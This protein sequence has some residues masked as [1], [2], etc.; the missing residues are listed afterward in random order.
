MRRISLAA[1]LSLTSLWFG[2]I[3]SAQQS[4]T[5]AVPNLIRYGGTLKDA[6]GA[7]IAATTGVTFAIYKQ[8]DGGA[9]VW[10]ETQNVTPD[11][12]GQYSVLLGSTTATGLPSDLFSQEEQRWLGVQVQGQAEQPRV[13]LVSVPYA[14][15][16][17]EAE[18]LAG[19]S[20]SDF[21][22]AKDL[23]SSQA[24]T[25]AGSSRAGTS[26]ENKLQTGKA[27]SKVAAASAGPTNFS[28]STTD[29]I[30]GVAQTGSGAG[31]NA[32]AST[33][34]VVG[35]ATGPSGIALYGIATSSN[36]IGVRGISYNPSGTGV[37]GSN[38]AG[39]GATT[40]ISAYVG[41]PSGTAAV[42]NNAAGGKIISGQ[43]NGVEKFSVG[44]SGNVTAAGTLSGNRTNT[45]TTYQ[46][47]GSTV[48]DIGHP[49]DGN[50]FVGAGAGVNN[51][52]GGDTNTF[53]G[54]LAG[55]ANT[56]GFGNTF[57]GF[58]AGYS[59][60]YGFY[61]TFSGDVAGY[62]NTTACCNVFS[63][64]GAG[65]FNTTGHDN[66]LIGYE[67]GYPNTTGYYNT[68]EGSLTGGST[69]GSHNI[70][71]GYA[72][73][74]N[75]STGSNDIYIANEGPSSGNESN[76]IRIGG[77]TG[78]GFGPQT[79]AYIAGIYGGL[80]SGGVSVYVNSNG[81]LGTGS[82][83]LRF[84]EQVR[85]MGDSSNAL[86]KLRPVTFFYRPEYDDGSHTLQYGLIAEE[87]AE[88]YPEMVAYD[89]DGQPYT[90]K[91]QYLA[92]MLLNELQ[93]QHAVVE[94]QQDV[95][96]MQQR[97]VNAQQGQIESLQKQDAE[98]QQRLARLESRAGRQR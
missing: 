39:S 22:L 94:A 34:A 26:A 72:A 38:S 8:Q 41:S 90:V 23:N 59:N 42:F 95:I 56:S 24:A 25:E 31:V 15:K 80:S 73:G 89:K 35:T 74:Y 12:G 47:G 48:L 86:R 82:S 64:F 33:H 79:A 29:Q 50:L 43:N 92:P 70:F 13:L 69:T 4:A 20:I 17:H 6:S 58:K 49:D 60:S 18:T 83:S 88:V 5:T 30:V 91:Y 7:A 21:V 54:S 84:K 57:S 40:G 19:K 2:S 77:D 63:G 85:D 61:N 78:L 14:L 52:I 27:G 76:T 28:G 45:A 81:Q 3:G 98:M 68:F 66:T 53:S 1:V 87:V 71:F 36:S 44:G 97:Q 62:S 51:G 16:A 65:A 93:K 32:T 96:E 37:R 75:N 55:Y 46:I 67:A 10:M 9:P 11:A